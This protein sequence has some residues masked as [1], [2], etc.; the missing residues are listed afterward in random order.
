MLQS[1]DDVSHRRHA[2]QGP[3]PIV[4]DAAT[5]RLLLPI[6]RQLHSVFVSGIHNPHS[7]RF[8]YDLTE[9]FEG[10]IGRYVDPQQPM[11]IRP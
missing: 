6:F 10:D 9:G 8:D 3:R 5:I 2:L 7:Y 4:V 1:S 11:G